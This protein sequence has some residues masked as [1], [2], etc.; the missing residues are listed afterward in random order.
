MAYN[1]N[2]NA[3]TAFKEM[4][5]VF[6]DGG[7]LDK[8]TNSGLDRETKALELIGKM[9]AIEEHK[10]DRQNKEEQFKWLQEAHEKTKTNEKANADFTMAILNG[11]GKTWLPMGDV[12][13][14][15]ASA[16]I[17]PLRRS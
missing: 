5:N 10:L 13:D 9:A 11:S 8:I 14:E 4:L 6:K 12:L 3:P 7:A 2:F 1:Y 17:T 16:T 15:K